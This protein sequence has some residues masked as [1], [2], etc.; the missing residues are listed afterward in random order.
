MIEHAIWRDMRRAIGTLFLVYCPTLVGAQELGFY[1]T[2][3]PIA[4][5]EA[6]CGGDEGCLTE[7]ANCPT[8]TDG[9]STAQIG[10]CVEPAQGGGQTEILCT[11]RL[12][13]RAVTLRRPDGSGVTLKR[14]NRTQRAALRRPDSNAVP[15]CLRYGA[16]RVI[17]FQPILDQATLIRWANGEGDT[18]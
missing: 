6:A 13:K 10:R 9:R 16:G 8:G 7:L 5:A 12:D 4:M 3:W 11:A 17:C 1:A 15:T 2:G 18:Q 14:A